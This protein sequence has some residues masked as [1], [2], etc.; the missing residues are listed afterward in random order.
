MRTLTSS[1]S[2]GECCNPNLGL[3]TKK[4]VG[5]VTS[6]EKSSRVTPHVFGNVRECEGT[7]PHIPK[8]ASILGVRVLM[9]SQ[10]FRTRLQ[11]SKFNGL[12]NYLYH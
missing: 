3:T 6:Q 2:G 4:R 9:D 10:I 5:K 1:F 12:N 11:G 7:K 8:G